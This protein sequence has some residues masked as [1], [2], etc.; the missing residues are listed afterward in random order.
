[1][2]NFRKKIVSIT[3]DI[4]V[5]GFGLSENNKNILLNQAINS[6]YSHRYII[7]LKIKF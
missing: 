5:E 4:S 1:M 3:G 7:K 6:N 2:P